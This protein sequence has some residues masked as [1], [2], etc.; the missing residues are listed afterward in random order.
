[1]RRFGER[2][3]GPHALRFVRGAPFV[4]KKRRVRCD[5]IEALYHTPDIAEGVRADIRVRVEHERVVVRA[6]LDRLRSP[7][8]CQKICSVT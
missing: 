4:V 8:K 5:E 3:F 7:N 6:P 1:M 2:V